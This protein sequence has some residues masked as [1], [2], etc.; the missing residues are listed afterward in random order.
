MQPKLSQD[1]NNK[2]VK[3]IA[4]F[5]MIKEGDKVLVGLSGGK[6]SSFLL[7]ALSVLQKYM[8]V[9]FQLEAVTVDPGFSSDTNFQPLVNLCKELEVDY[10]LIKTRIAEYILAEENT[11]PCSKCAHFRKGAIIK[12]MLANNFNKLAFGH[13]YDDAVETFLMSIIYSGQLQT[14]QP[15]RFLSESEINLIRPLIYLREKDIIAEQ[16]KI[17][18]QILQS[19]CPYDTKSARAVIRNKYQELF[20]DKQIF[21][22]I[23]KAMREG[24]NIELWPEEKSYEQI[25]QAM[26]YLWTKNTSPN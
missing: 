25:S 22:N 11:N 19:P 8:A 21:S 7:Y 16:K 26:K 20:N 14:L 12:Y 1:M 9:N 4:E 24:N 23:S 10:H 3:A 13:H 17:G 5:E 2:I 6:D 15:V 18:Y